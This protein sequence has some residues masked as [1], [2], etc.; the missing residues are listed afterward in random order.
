M[1][2]S[3]LLRI[4]GVT[5]RVRCET[6]ITP[7][8]PRPIAHPLFELIKMVANSEVTVNAQREEKTNGRVFH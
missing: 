8:I 4:N 7:K 5:C 2:E 1:R 6:I 3:K